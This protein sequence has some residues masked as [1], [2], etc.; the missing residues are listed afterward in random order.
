MSIVQEDCN[1]HYRVKK[2][3]SCFLLVCC[4]SSFTSQIPGMPAIALKERKNTFG[5]AGNGGA[6]SITKTSDGGYAVAGFTSSNNGDVFGNHGSSDMWIG[7]FNEVGALQWQKLLG[8]TEGDV[9]NSIIYTTDGG[10]VVAGYTRSNDGDVSGYHGGL[11]YDLWIVKINTIGTIEWQKALGGTYDDIAYSV[12]QTT[13]GGYLVAGSTASNDGDVS[14]NHGNTDI[15][16]VKLSE[17]GNIQWQRAFGGTSD[18]Y[19]YSVTQTT[20]GGYLV[21]GST[22]SNN[23]DVSGNHG[24]RDI[25]MAKLSD[26]G[27]LQWKKT[28]GGTDEDI[29][30]SVIQTTDGGYLVAG[31]TWSNN[32]NVSGNHGHGDMCVI[33]LSG[34][35]AIQWKKVLGGSGNDEGYSIIQATDG[36]YVA[37]GYTD[38]NNDG[39]VSGNQGYS[40][41]WV[42][43]L[44]ATGNIQWQKAVGGT[45]HNQANSII[46]ITDGKYVVAGK[47]WSNDGD[48][49]GPLNGYYDFF[50]P[51]LTAA[52]NVIRLYEDVP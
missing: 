46:Q 28:L 10:Y 49:S 39:D 8:G 17:T 45:N 16:V 20:D 14:G 11:R 24:G 43:K 44:S 18:E 41:V 5:G 52:G 32:G 42:V 50:I 27:T 1:M 51:M 26:I 31:S 37:A 34:T 30:Y 12:I 21:A 2:Y 48:V 19:G 35:G 9:A 23:G 47:T 15:W 3:F 38:S 6:N 7:K 36:G 22:A 13:E 40:N 29:A 25:W 33:K 4:L